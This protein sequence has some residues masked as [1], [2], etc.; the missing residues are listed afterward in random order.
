MLK[1]KIDLKLPTALLREK[2]FSRRYVLTAL[3]VLESAGL[4]T[5]KRYSFKS[6]EITLITD[7]VTVAKLEKNF[8]IPVKAGHSALERGNL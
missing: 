6:P 4:I 5:V 7:Q 1:N 8:G 3:K 2:G